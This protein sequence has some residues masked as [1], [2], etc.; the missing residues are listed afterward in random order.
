MVALIATDIGPIIHEVRATLITEIARD[1]V[2]GDFCVLSVV[3]G[4]LGPF[5]ASPAF[6]I[7]QSYRAS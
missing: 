4:V 1:E 3:S 7:Q 6:R 5:Q 2:S